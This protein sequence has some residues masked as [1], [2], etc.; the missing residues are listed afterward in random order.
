MNLL[1]ALQA[2]RR[3]EWLEAEGVLDEIGVAPRAVPSVRIPH[4]T[5]IVFALEDRVGDVVGAQII[6]R[7]DAGDSGAD[8]DDAEISAIHRSPSKP[9]SIARITAAPAECTS[10][11]R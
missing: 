8:D 5:H 7:A 11:L 9:S 3:Q 10:S 4:S 1:P 6:G 2:L